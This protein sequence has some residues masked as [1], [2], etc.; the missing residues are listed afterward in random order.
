MR[1]VVYWEYENN[2][3][4]L[5]LINMIICQY[6]GNIWRFGTLH[7]YRVPCSVRSTDLFIYSHKRYNR[8]KHG[9]WQQ[10]QNKLDPLQ[11]FINKK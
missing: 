2:T 8:A 11:S 1:C 9:N 3:S 7:Q 6:I 5:Q 4:L 10:L